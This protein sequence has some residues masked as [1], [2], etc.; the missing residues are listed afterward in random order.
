[1]VGVTGSIPVAP[2]MFVPENPTFFR[3][4][5]GSLSCLAVPEQ[6]SNLAQKLLQIGQS[7]GRM[8]TQGSAR[9]IR[10]IQEAF[11]RVAG[12]PE[13]SFSDNFVDLYPL[14][15]AVTSATADGEA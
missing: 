10:A 4:V 13:T 15:F 8:F 3:L 1:M 6:T 5:S 14:Y 11:R 7:V 9:L 2:T 12:C